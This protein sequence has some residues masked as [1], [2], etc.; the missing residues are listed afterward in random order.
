MK[1]IPQVFLSLKSDLRDDIENWDR[2]GCSEALDNELKQFDKS[3]FAIP[4]TTGGLVAQSTTAGYFWRVSILTDQQAATLN[5]KIFPTILFYDVDTSKHVGRVEGTGQLRGAIAA[6]LNRIFGL[7][8]NQV[9][10]S[11]LKKT[12]GYSL[13]L[14]A[15]LLFVK[16]KAVQ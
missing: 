8:S 4:S 7:N 3:K 16:K 2:F 13:A 5:I 10:G 12:A 6:E 11:G 1:I 9:L 15:L 14:L